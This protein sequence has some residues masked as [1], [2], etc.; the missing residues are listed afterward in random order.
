M[1][2]SIQQDIT[3]TP[4]QQPYTVAEGA[5]NLTYTYGADYNRIKSE[6]KQNGN[7]IQT[8][9]YF[10]SFEKDGSGRYIH[11]VSA[12][13][14]L[15]AIVENSS[16]I[17]YTY[18][19]HLGS[20]LAVTNGSGS[21][22]AEQNFDP[23][24]RRRDPTSWALLAPTAS[25]GLPDWLYRGY[26]GH[27][28]LD[29]FGLI[30][31]NGRLYD[32]VLGRVLSPDNYV[33][34]VFGTQDYNRYT[35]AHNN[36]LLYNDPDGN[37]PL[38]GALAGG[39][40]YTLGI[41]FSKGGFKNWSW[42]GFSM[43]VV[44]GAIMGGFASEVGASLATAS[45]LSV[46]AKGAI[47]AGAYAF[48]GG[49]TSYLSG[50][51]FLSGAAGGAAGS[52]VGSFMV[53]LT[54]GMNGFWSAAST[55]GASSLTGGVGAELSGGDFWRGAVTSGLTAAFN[56][57]AHQLDLT[58]KFN[59]QLRLTRDYFSMASR[60]LDKADLNAISKFKYK[61]DFFKG[62][63]GTGRPFDL[64]VGAYSERSIGKES[65]YEGETFAPQDYGNYNFGVAAKSFG[66]SLNFAEWGAGI[67]QIRS[68]T[69]QFSWYYR[70]F[71]DPRD[72]NM[73]KRGFNH[74]K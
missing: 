35:Y 63:V 4:F 72:G 42:F 70:K 13:V 57:A 56:H 48:M 52:V 40:A 44:S 65:F 5:F 66:Y 10:S 71:D 53:G 49:T 68:G 41:A 32:P 69:S 73:I 61:M 55:I 46:F 26:T 31:M 12:P 50:G 9:Y 2:P 33:Q 51:D 22:E 54:S 64:K 21:I 39:V 16:T 30:N 74:F 24:G 47:Q 1:I 25:T 28:H 27:E 14:G 60:E 37:N 20:I 62:E 29:Q 38:I 36:P 67:Y 34:N 3:Y 6:L 23:W 18:T 45:N 15:I 19:D 59:K 58:R 8:R 17:H 43:S 7:T 11:Y